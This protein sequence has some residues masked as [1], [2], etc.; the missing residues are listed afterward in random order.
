MTDLQKHEEIKD[1]S[2][3]IPVWFVV[4]RYLESN[5]LNKI[6]IFT[7]GLRK[8]TYKRTTDNLSVY[9]VELVALYWDYSG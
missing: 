9:T 6:M 3:Q 4:Q 5:F 8:W 2:K 7:D 1:N